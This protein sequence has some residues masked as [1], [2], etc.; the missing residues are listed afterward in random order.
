MLLV[1]G[2]EHLFVFPSAHDAI[3]TAEGVE[4]FVLKEANGVQLAPQILR[5]LGL[6]PSGQ[7]P[8]IAGVV[9]E[10][11]NRLGLLALSRRTLDLDR[12]VNRQITAPA[13]RPFDQSL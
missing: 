8:N 3:I 2:L 4:I 10:G 1:L 7:D 12:F 11:V 9:L 5:A 6:R 13:G